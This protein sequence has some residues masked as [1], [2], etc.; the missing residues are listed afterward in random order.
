[1][2]GISMR[3]A[4]FLLVVVL[5]SYN[6]SLHSADDW[7]QWRGPTSDSKALGADPT[8][9][10]GPGENVV[11]R[12]AVPGRG[13]SSPTVVGDQIFITTADE[14]AKAQLVISY[15]RSTGKEQWRLTAFKGG[16]DKKAHKRNSQASCSVAS[17]GERLFACFM[18]GGAV[19]LLAIDLEGKEIWRKRV[20][21]FV[22]YWGY[23]ASP[24]LH[25]GNVIVAADHSEGG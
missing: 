11:W 24:T 10:W 12:T 9:T 22:S 18:N 5:A 6:N 4:C 14:Q 13:H 7:P 23:G 1:M 17:N 15:R 21:D 25:G 19:W 16:F 2:A 8:L 3:G 20:G